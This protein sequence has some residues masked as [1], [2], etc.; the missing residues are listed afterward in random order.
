MLHN[1]NTGKMSHI[2]NNKYV[3]TC[4]EKREN[5]AHFDTHH[6]WCFAYGKVVMLFNVSE[7]RVNQVAT[8]HVHI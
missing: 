1:P 2:Y 7:S 4:E 8:G 5:V 6:E 3:D